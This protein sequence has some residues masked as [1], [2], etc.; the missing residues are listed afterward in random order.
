MHSFGANFKQTS[1]LVLKCF[2]NIDAHSYEHQQCRLVLKKKKKK[3]FRR[4]CKNKATQNLP[5]GLGAF[6]YEVQLQPSWKNKGRIHSN[7]EIGN[8][9]CVCVCGA[10]G[11]QDNRHRHTHTHSA[12]VL[13]SKPA[14]ERHSVLRARSSHSLAMC[15][16]DCLSLFLT[17]SPLL[18]PSL[19]V[20]GWVIDRW[21]SLEP[22]HCV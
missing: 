3:R 6:P 12:L 15:L 8:P 4:D 1:S 7:R 14:S 5:P 22:A 17:L 2:S 18:H 10:V 13:W 11:E 16:P 21:Q 20:T 9:K 19:S